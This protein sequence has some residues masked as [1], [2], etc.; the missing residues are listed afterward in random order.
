MNK[1]RLA[2]HS[3]DVISSPLWKRLKQIKAWV[4]YVLLKV[5]VLKLEARCVTTLL[6]VTFVS[7]LKMCSSKM[8]EWYRFKG[9]KRVKTRNVRSSKKKKVEILLLLY[10]LVRGISSRCII[11]PEGTLKG[12]FPFFLYLEKQ[13][14]SC[15]APNFWLCSEGRFEHLAWHFH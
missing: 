15:R 12:S 6:I 2:Q 5:L 7:R 1:T 9:I 11:R 13:K 10:S 4:Y 14:C 8:K 3:S